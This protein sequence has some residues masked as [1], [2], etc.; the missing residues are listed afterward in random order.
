MDMEGKAS[1]YKDVRCLISK[2]SIGVY[3]L[4]PGA[5]VPRDQP[6]LSTEREAC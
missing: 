4:E 3:T 5:A 2:H 6:Q 1:L